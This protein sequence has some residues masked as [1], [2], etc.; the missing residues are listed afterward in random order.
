MA[1]LRKTG[2]F[3]KAPWARAARFT[4][5]DPGRLRDADL[6]LIPPSA[7]WLEAM[8]ASAE[9]PTSLLAEPRRFSRAQLMEF[10][11]L[12]PLGQQQADSVLGHCPAYYFWML[13]HSRPDLPIAGTISLRIGHTD[14]LELYCGHVGYH[15][16]PP[17]RGHHLAERSVRLLLPLARR[18]GLDPLWITCN[19]DNWASRRTCQRLG[20]VLVQ[21]V[22]VPAGHPL[23]TRGERTKC[24]FRLD[25]A[26]LA[27]T[28][29]PGPDAAS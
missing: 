14:D 9:H 7:S 19:P 26:D 10:L 15:V 5:L 2:W 18:H 28:A 4:F 20:A 29:P 1:M 3:A 22:A 6:E 24:R 12:H 23:H 13:D 21:T 11:V 25:F 17:H 16:F 27:Q 8:V